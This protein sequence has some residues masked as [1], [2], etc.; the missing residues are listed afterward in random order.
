MPSVNMFKILHRDL[1]KVDTSRPV[2]ISDVNE[3][4][5]YSWIEGR[6]PVISVPG[7][8][9]LWTP[10]PGRQTMD[11]D[12]GLVYIDQN[13]A[14]LPGRSMEP[15]F[16][17]L[18]KAN[19]SFD[20]GSVDVITD[21]NNIR[22]LLSFINPSRDSHNTKPF[23]INVQAIKNTIIFGRTESATTEVIQAHE[24]RGFGREYEK[25]YTS[26]EYPNMAGHHRVISYR[27][28]DMAFVVR[29]EAD[30]YVPPSKYVRTDTRDSGL[31]DL[32]GNLSL[33][34]HVNAAAQ[35]TSDKPQL[36]VQGTGQVVPLAS[37]L[38][39][40]TRAARRP[41]TFDEVAPQLWA[42]QTPNL[43]RAYHDRGAFVDSKVENVSRSIRAWEEANQ[44]DLAKLGA[45][46]ARIRTV[47]KNL[48]GKATVT[49]DVARTML[50]INPADDLTD[51][52]PKDIY[53]KWE[54]AMP[55]AGKSYGN[56]DLA[57]C[58]G[59]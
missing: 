34:P 26:N 17:S 15:L 48:G 33:S 32:L 29:Y 14:R 18:F 35:D 45:L 4:S 20:L 55:T 16:R 47:A 3:L 24:F 52:V 36:R 13:A 53:A 51:M 9:P 19:P 25:R 6:L 54:T 57:L 8:P 37:I 21:R 5:S 50:A 49:F 2:S 30:A 31:S 28:C 56:P 41:L 7:L 11:K 43:V 59:C 12:S 22:K 44:L 46:I 1:D 38:E 40:K 58:P 27:F 39:I 10:L 23:T 42:S